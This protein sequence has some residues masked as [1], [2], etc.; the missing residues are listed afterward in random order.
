MIFTFGRVEFRGKEGR[1]WGE[2]AGQ[3]CG[4]QRGLGQAKWFIP[5]AAQSLPQLIICLLIHELWFLWACFL[6]IS[7]NRGRRIRRAGR[8]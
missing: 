3:L 5:E 8:G 2:E 7:A 4:Q 6:A 1:P